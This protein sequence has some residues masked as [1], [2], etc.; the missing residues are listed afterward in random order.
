VEKFEK[1]YL[2][3][4]TLVNWILVILK[5]STISRIAGFQLYSGSG[6]KK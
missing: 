1:K 4:A 3:A 2:P 6:A 5:F